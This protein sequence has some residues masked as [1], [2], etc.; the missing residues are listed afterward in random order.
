MKL[1]GRILDFTAI[2]LFVIS[3]ILFFNPLF[4]GKVL[5]QSDIQQHEGMAKEIK[6]YQE[7]E[8]QTIHWTNSM[9]GGMPTYLLTDSMFRSQNLPQFIN[10]TIRKW[11]PGVSAIFLIGLICY[12]ILMRSLLINQW[13]GI[14]ASFVF[15]SGTFVISSLI[16]GHTSKINAYAYAP[17]ILAGL[18]YIFRKKPLA[19]IFLLAMGLGAQ[20]AVNH[21]QITFYTFLICLVF[22]ISA[23][24]KWVKEES[25][26]WWKPLVFASIGVA[27]ALGVNFNKLTTIYNHSAYTIRGDKSELAANDANQ[28]KAT[29]ADYQYATQW[30]YG[31]LETNTLLIPNFMGGSSSEH[32]GDKSHLYNQSQLPLSFRENPPTYWGKMP[33]TSAPV[34]LGAVLFTCLFLGFFL[35]KNSQKWWIIIASVL[36]IFLAWGKYSGIYNLFYHYFPF[37]DKFRTPMMALLMLGLTIPILAFLGLDELTKSTNQLSKKSLYTSFGIPFIWVV[38]FGLLGGLLYSFSGAVDAQLTS[39]GLPNNLLSLL[40]QDRKMLLRNDSWRS[41]FF[42]VTTALLLYQFWNKKLKLRFF[43]IGLA[44]LLFL[45]LFMVNKRYLTAKS[46]ETKSNYEQVFQPNTVD[47]EI[48]SDP[49]LYYRVFN[50]TRNPF[51]DAITSYNHKSIGGYH[52]AKLQRYQD[53]IER[54]LSEQDEASINMLNTKYYIGSSQ[55]GQLSYQKNENAMGNAWFV[56]NVYKA[57]DAKDA[58]E[59]LSK[60]DIR[61]NAIVEETEGKF[62][63]ITTSVDSLVDAQI[64]LTAYHPEHLEFES[65]QNSGQ[66]QFAVFSDIYY[67]Q[68]DGDGWHAYVDGTEV[69]LFKT[70]YVLRGIEVPTGTHNI[71]FRYVKKAFN[72]RTGIS[73]LFS[74]LILLFGIWYFAYEALIKSKNA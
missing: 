57:N 20:I 38:L 25:K 50:L 18:I 67:L 29:D 52:A 48:K 22:F 10:Y 40:K 6:D 72:S 2:A 65:T 45:D 37:F 56:P 13:L 32:L 64:N 61:K 66:P 31:T 21:L 73:R 59:Q 51:S 46:Y 39:M 17:L 35:T 70:N 47:M 30:S 49:S 24:I 1:E 41:L 68:S 53:L 11:F 26:A 74:G 19:G 58:F 34:Y 54:K 3:T 16:A 36:M 69:P 42:I 23:Y 63:D 28:S 7:K 12:Y 14:L 43:F 8:H 15:A 33:G 55:E 44:V 71:E 9:F 27:L 4:S 60:K 62:P 5:V